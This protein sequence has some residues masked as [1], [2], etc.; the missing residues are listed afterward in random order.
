MP[1]SPTQLVP[2]TLDEVPKE[3]RPWVEAALVVPINRL[4]ETL[5]SAFGNNISLGTNINAQVIE[6]KFTAPN[7]EID[8]DAFRFDTPLNLITGPVSGVQVLGCWTVDSAGHDVEPISGLATP[9]WR[10]VVVQ[11][12]RNLRL[13]QQPGLVTGTKYRLVLLAWGP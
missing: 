12:K 6:R 5:R 9:K 1:I 13:I 10:E 3:M 2:L 7:D 11:G 4:I 8:W